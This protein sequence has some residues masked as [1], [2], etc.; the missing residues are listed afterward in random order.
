MKTLTTSRRRTRWGTGI[1]ALIAG[2]ALALTSSPASAATIDVDYDVNGTT[3]IEKTGSTITLGPAVMHSFVEDDGSFTGDMV[4]PGTR[5]EFK[6][7]GFI[8]VTA[9]V[10]FTPTKPTTGQLTRVGR[11]RV[12]TS[13]SSYYVRL[14]NIKASIF[15]LFAGQNCRT[16]DPVV[17]PAN[18]PEGEFFD[19]A[20]G[21]RLVGEYTLGEFENCGLN[22]WLINL[23]VPGGGNTIEL[24]LTNGRLG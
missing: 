21:G 10:N 12:L 24:N 18:T 5:T 4:L 16:V 8:P 3:Q 13:E 14:S 15:P 23:L 22:T 19:I 11:Q 1:A 9:D 6:V 7:I 17:I 2:A 20:A